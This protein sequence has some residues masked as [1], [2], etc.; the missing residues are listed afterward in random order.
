MVKQV[1]IRAVATQ[2]LVA[3][4]ANGENA[5]LS[6]FLAKHTDESTSLSEFLQMEMDCLLESLDINE[7]EGNEAWS[8]L[9]FV[10]ILT[11]LR[12]T[13]ELMEL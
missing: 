12:K 11:D 2:K 10:I 13:F 7:L 3:A 4:L 6:R 8:I 5:S 1:N 9:R